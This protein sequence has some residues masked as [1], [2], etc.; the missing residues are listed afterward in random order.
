VGLW[1]NVRK[2][3]ETFSGQTRFA[4]RDG[5]KI[6]FGHDLW[7]GDMTLMAAFPALFGIAV[8][9]DASVANNLEL[10]GGFNQ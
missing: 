5:T 7:V 9:K 2:G 6:S 8:V 1:K 3:W 4:V 10:F